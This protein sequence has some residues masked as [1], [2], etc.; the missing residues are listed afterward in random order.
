MNKQQA[1]KR[2]A[3]KLAP[4]KKVDLAW[5]DLTAL[6][7]AAGNGDQ[8]TLLGALQR[9]NADAAGRH[10][11]RLVT[12]WAR[13]AAVTEAEALLAND[14]LDLDELEKVL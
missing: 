11:L 10:L 7:A 2:L 8:Q 12:G 1:I 14:T 4:R 9:D 5:D 13:E 6:L 3:K